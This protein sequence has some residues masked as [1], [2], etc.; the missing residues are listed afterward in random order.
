MTAIHKINITSS[1]VVAGDR[2]TLVNRYATV[3]K[4]TSDKA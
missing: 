3:S 1:S 2:D 4:I